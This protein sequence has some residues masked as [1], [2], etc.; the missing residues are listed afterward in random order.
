MSTIKAG[1]HTRLSDFESCALK[2]KIKYIDKVKE[3]EKPLPPG[4]TEHA[5][6]R[7]TRIHDAAE[8]F[9]KGGVELIP[10]LQRFEREFHK[11]REMHKN[12]L[13]STE[14]DWGY[15]KDWEP[16]AWNSADVYIRIKCDLVIHRSP[17]DIVVVDYKSGKR[18]GNEIKHGEQMQ[19]Y[20]LGTIFRYPKAKTITTELWYLDLDELTSMTY[21]RD[22]GMRFVTNYDRR[23]SRMMAETEFK[24]NP[25]PH[26]CKWC[27]WKPVHLGGNGMCKV[28]V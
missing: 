12:G 14:G 6:D 16:V 2:A 15:N 23:L 1:S 3:P 18:F 21:T 27:P 19:L 4:K 28:G 25:N 7:G 22:Q 26:S 13:A 10:E 11:A 8:R 5:N 17:S 20:V 24:P 9:I